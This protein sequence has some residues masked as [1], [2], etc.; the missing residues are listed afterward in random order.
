MARDALVFHVDTGRPSEVADAGEGNQHLIATLQV[1]LQ[2]GGTLCNCTTTLEHDDDEE[3]EAVAETVEE[4]EDDAVSVEE[5]DDAHARNQKRKRDEM[6]D[7]I[8]SPQNHDE[9]SDAVSQ[10]E[11]SEQSDDDSDDSN[12]QHLISVCPELVAAAETLLPYDVAAYCLTVLGDLKYVNGRWYTDPGD[13]PWTL[14]ENAEATIILRI[15]NDVRAVTS[16]T[17]ALDN[18]PAV[19]L[20][21][22]KLA[23]RNFRKSIIKDMADMCVANKQEAASHDASTN[24]DMLAD[25]MAVNIK[26]TGN[27]H[28]FVLL[29]DLVE[30]YKK[31]EKMRRQMSAV[32]FK[33]ITKALLG[34]VALS[35]KDVDN[36]RLS[37]GKRLTQRCVARGCAVCK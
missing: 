34:T 3:D 28:D 26:V 37:D 4:D 33:R 13:G 2:A 30:R 14:I 11:E 9:S 27:K 7:G 16:T 29:S 10:S 17:A 23:E 5:D 36:I 35:F 24:K 21:S 8:V 18:N 32:E 22:N 15:A 20:L 25:W 6:E 12:Q 31:D 1:A 19:N